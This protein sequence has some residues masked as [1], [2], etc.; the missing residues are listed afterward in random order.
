MTDTAESL[1]REAAQMV[2]HEC[3]NT[4][5]QPFVCTTCGAGKLYDAT[6]Q[7]VQ[8]RAEKAEAENAAL[9]DEMRDNGAYE[10]GEDT[11]KEIRRECDLKLAKFAAENAALRRGEFICQ[12]CSLRKDSEHDEPIGF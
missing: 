12:R 7:V 1:L 8:E 3:K 4:F 9:R 6:L 2:C 5:R 11:Y 10:Q